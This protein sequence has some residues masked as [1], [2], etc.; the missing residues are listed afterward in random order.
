[1]SEG[2][3]LV[4]AALFLVNVLT[5]VWIVAMRDSLR[6]VIC[7]IML[8]GRRVLAVRLGMHGPLF[9]QRVANADFSGQVIRIQNMPRHRMAH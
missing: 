2:G 4:S 9:A 8:N 6:V 7:K 5:D 3:F 1:M